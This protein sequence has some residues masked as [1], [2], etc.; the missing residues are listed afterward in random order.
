VDRRK[1]GGAGRG[2]VSPAPP[3]R[4][5]MRQVRRKILDE[6]A[7]FPR[8]TRSRAQEVDEIRQRQASEGSRR[9]KKRRCPT[10]GVVHRVVEAHRCTGKHHVIMLCLAAG[11]SRSHSDSPPLGGHNL[12]G[13]KSLENEK[14]DGMSIRVEVPKSRKR[15][16]DLDDKRQLH[17]GQTKI[18]ACGWRFFFWRMAT[19]D[20]LGGAARIRAIFFFFFFFFCFFDNPYGDGA[21]A[22]LD[23][24]GAAC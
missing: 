21:P 18:E 10:R 24:S 17:G 4:A 11:R 6:G 1:D 2:A 20:S 16:P 22:F 8:N 7:A 9:A 13:K 15:F 19:T 5:A 14:K 23:L 3:R 12:D